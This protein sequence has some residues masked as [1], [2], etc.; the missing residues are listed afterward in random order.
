MRNR[1]DPRKEPE[2]PQELSD[3][4]FEASDELRREAYED[5]KRVEEQSKMAMG[6]IGAIALV[7]TFWGSRSVVPWGVPLLLLAVALCQ[8]ATWLRE[9]DPKRR[10]DE[11]M[12]LMEKAVRARRREL[13]MLRVS[14]SA[15]ARAELA[16]NGDIFSERMD[17]RIDVVAADF[18]DGSTAAEV[19][20]WLVEPRQLVE[21]RQP[22]ANVLYDSWT[23]EFVAPT[24]GRVEELL[25]P[26]SQE[27]AIGTPLCVISPAR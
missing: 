27:V 8:L 2:P 4:V 26:V 3:A 22:I 25:I 6:V 16:D 9:R 19:L 21:A 7:M 18:G 1:P 23:L 17:G 13:T 10:M 14:Q 5:W 20:E 24:K 15:R 12:E 11:A